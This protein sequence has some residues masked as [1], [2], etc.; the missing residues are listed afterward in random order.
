MIRAVW[1]PLSRFV[2]SKI[3]LPVLLTLRVAL[4]D[5]AVSATLLIWAEWRRIWR[6]SDSRLGQ[7]ELKANLLPQTQL[8]VTD[9]QKTSRK[10]QKKWGGLNG[11]NIPLKG[12]AAACEPPTRIRII[13][14]I[15]QCVLETRACILSK[16]DAK[17]VFGTGEICWLQTWTKT[18]K[19]VYCIWFIQS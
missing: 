8:S 11:H 18:T 14:P 12:D 6:D 19:V 5:A 1:T 15:I 10:E 13:I 9:Q 17:E 3:V 2:F 4:L 16:L 7:C